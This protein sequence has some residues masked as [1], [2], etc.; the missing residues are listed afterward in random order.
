MGLTG[1]LYTQISTFNSHSQPPSTGKE[2]T[3]EMPDITRGR[4]LKQEMKHLETVLQLPSL[5]HPRRKPAE[6]TIR[7]PKA[8][9]I[10]YEHRRAE[11]RHQTNRQ[12]YQHQNS[13]HPTKNPPTVAEPSERVDHMRLWKGIHQ[14][15]PESPRH[16]DQGTPGCL[17]Q[18]GLKNLRSWNMPSAM[19]TELTGTQW[20]SWILP[21]RRWSYWWKQR[22][23][24]NE[25]QGAA[26]KSRY[27][28]A[29]SRVLECDTLN[30]HDVIKRSWEQSIDGEAQ[31]MEMDSWQFTSS[32]FVRLFRRS[33]LSSCIF[34][35]FH[36]VCPEEGQHSLAEMLALI[37]TVNW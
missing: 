13:V 24:F 6:V 29:N 9:R 28:L 36:R 20:R 37:I 30:R 12:K 19:T 22:F 27:W 21:Q 11:Q 33:Y 25:H 23:T 32:F 14:W 5:L 10:N 4:E 26:T 1:S 31:G 16:E 17:P 34:L 8:A 18:T 15:N 3:G 7:E 2:G 35:Y